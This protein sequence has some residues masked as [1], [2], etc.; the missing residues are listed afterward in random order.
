MVM[1]ELIDAQK[2]IFV[3][4]FACSG[5]IF[6]PCDIC[7][8]FV[9]FFFFKENPQFLRRDN[10]REIL[11]VLTLMVFFGGLLL[12]HKAVLIWVAKPYVG[13]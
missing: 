4:H 8:V 10:L 6:K 12:I 7:F 11:E 5:M 13:F 1:V 2:I 9:L 3:I